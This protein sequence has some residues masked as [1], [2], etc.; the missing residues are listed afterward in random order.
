M[1]KDK[2][3]IEANLP[4]RLPKGKRSRSGSY[5]VEETATMARE[6]RE[7]EQQGH[8]K[9]ARVNAR[10]HHPEEQHQAALEGDMHNQILEHPE[11]AN[12]Q[13]YAGIANTLSVPDQNTDARLKFDNEKRE[14]DKEKNLRLENALGLGSTPKFSPKPG[15]P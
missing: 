3:D 4:D 7:A 11:L 15:G 9:L 14:Q 12:N 1:S 8:R 6:Q 2:K 13:H 5:L 10:E